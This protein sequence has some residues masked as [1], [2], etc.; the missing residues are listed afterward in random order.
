MKHKHK[1]TKIPALHT[2][3][4]A[5]TLVILLKLSIVKTPSHPVQPV[6]ASADVRVDLVNTLMSD[7]GVQDEL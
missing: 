5:P 7:T 1:H 3:K 4:V 6:P 2:R